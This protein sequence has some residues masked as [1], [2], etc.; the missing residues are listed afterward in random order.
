MAK[1]K[2]I[3]EAIFP[4]LG[5]YNIK[6]VENYVV[7]TKEELSKALKKVSIPCYM[8]G[9]SVADLHKSDKGLVREITSEQ[10]AFAFFD[11]L[12]E[13]NDPDLFAVVQKRATG[14]EIFIGIK[15]DNL[16]NYIFLFGLGGV[17]VEVYRDISYGILPVSKSELLEVIA[18]T[19]IGKSLLKGYRGYG[20]DVDYIYNLLRNSYKMLKENDYSEIEF[21][22][23]IISKKGKTTAVDVKIVKE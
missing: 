22:P 13:T 20:I 15:K 11:E 2:T 5:I 21:N 6:L 4:E 7:S 17:F 19:K 14:V 3:E 16:F 1:L 9:V 8:K 10:E 12:K 18:Q 23:I